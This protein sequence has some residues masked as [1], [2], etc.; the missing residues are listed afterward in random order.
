MDGAKPDAGRPAK[1]ANV[2]FTEEFARLRASGRSPVR[3]A[4][5]WN[6]G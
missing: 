5:P 6:L 1:I 3:M 2:V 4:A